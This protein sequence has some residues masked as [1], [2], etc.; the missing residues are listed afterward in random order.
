MSIQLNTNTN[1][2]IPLHYQKRKFFK[3]SVIFLIAL[4]FFGF[5]GMHVPIMNEYMQKLTPFES[6]ISLTPLNLLLTSAM[7]LYFHKDWN[8]QFFVYV[9]MA[10][11]TGF[12]AEVLG[13]ATGV[14]FGEYAYGATLGWKFLEVPLVIGINWF[15]LSYV[16]SSLMFGVSSNIYIRTM[17]ASLLMVILDLL[18]EPVAIKYDF[19]T[20]A[21]NEI[22]LQNYF[23]WF[24]IGLIPCFLF[25]F[26]NFKK[27]NLFA[28]YVFG[29]QLMF[30]F[31]NNL[32]I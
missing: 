11:L 5:L 10:M 14:I 22:P 8:R 32:F 12:F 4:Y 21:G 27:Q 29:A 13:V 7:L 28:V 1:Q 2:N 18:I 23:A 16:C 20:W 31:L 9:I 24:I 15:L 19:W 25:Y 26:L 30:F 3:P 17:A 6:F